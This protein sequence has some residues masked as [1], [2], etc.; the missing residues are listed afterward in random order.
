MVA[1]AE[2]A[3]AEAGEERCGLG[4]GLASAPSPGGALEPPGEEVASVG[5]PRVRRVR[6]LLRFRAPATPCLIVSSALPLQ[7][8]PVYAFVDCALSVSPTALSR[9][10]SGETV[11]WLAAKFN[12][13]QHPASSGV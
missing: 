6:P 2:P 5:Q 12:L 8:F 10:C 7:L 13:T 1:W 3:G 9:R 11:T 4:W